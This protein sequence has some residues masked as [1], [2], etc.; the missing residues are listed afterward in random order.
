MI[1]LKNC[2]VCKHRKLAFTPPDALYRGVICS[3][4][5][6]GDEWWKYKY[7]GRYKILRNAK[8]KELKNYPREL[9]LDGTQP[10][11]L[12]YTPQS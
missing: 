10:E 1:K 11:C 6:K 9:E 7:V 3:V 8:G 5:A 12:A 2:I 4:N